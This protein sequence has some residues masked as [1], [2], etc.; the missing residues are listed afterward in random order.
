MK[1]HDL[2]HARHDPAHCLAPG[3]FRS[4]KRGD[5]KK[6]KLDVVYQL[7]ED[8]TIEFSGPE[9][10]GVD[11]MRILQGL[12]AM[13]GPVGIVLSADPKTEGGKQLRLFLEPRWESAN[14]NAMVVKGSFRNLAKEIGYADIDGGKTFRDI[15]ACIERLW[16]VSIIA[17]QG[18]RRKGYRLLSEYASDK[19]GGKL[20]VALNPRITQSIMGE[21]QHSRIDMQ[22]VRALKTDPARLIHQRLSAWVDR[23]KKRRVTIDTLMGYAWPDKCEASGMRDRKTK[24]QKALKEIQTAGWTIK[25]YVQGKYEITR[26]SPRTNSDKTP[27]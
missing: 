3:L 20:F 14:E 21:R 11:D 9:P 7:S 25:E 6:F 23:G 1:K 24:A 13:A 5:R 19:A 26:P 4:L 22:E 16:K 12:V 8:E 15:R 27:D 18:P 17:R 2:T 10:L